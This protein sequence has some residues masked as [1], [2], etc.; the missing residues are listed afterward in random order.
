VRRWAGD[1][2]SEQKIIIAVPS[3]RAE[4]PARDECQRGGGPEAVAAMVAGAARPTLRPASVRARNKRLFQVTDSHHKHYDHGQFIGLSRKPRKPRRPCADALSHSA[5]VTAIANHCSSA[6]GTLAF[7]S[8]AASDTRGWRRLRPDYT[9]V[10]TGM[11]AKIE[12]P[13]DVTMK[14]RRRPGRTRR[15]Q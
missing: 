1:I 15:R 4:R 14:R 11:I 2:D 3:R 6:A 13:L 10:A 8:G 5:S 9:R 7:I 12:S